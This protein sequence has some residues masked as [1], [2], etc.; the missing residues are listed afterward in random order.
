MYNII[1]TY[2]VRPP[3]MRIITLGIHIIILNYAIM[4]VWILYYE[5]PVEL[6]SWI[7][8]YVVQCRTKFVLHP[9]KLLAYHFE[10][11]MTLP[12]ARLIR[13][14]WDLITI[15]AWLSYLMSISQ[16]RIIISV[17]KLPW[18]YL[19][20]VTDIP[21]KTHHTLSCIQI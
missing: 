7:Y 3:Y 11:I 9:S 1:I 2:S 19:L 18:P 10:N 15:I 8:Y 20:Q 14:H 21:K 13:Y 4:S 5:N 12:I 17:V 16:T 6:S